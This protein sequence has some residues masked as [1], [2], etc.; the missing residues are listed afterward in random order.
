MIETN[1]ERSLLA[2]FDEQIQ[3]RM[4]EANAKRWVDDILALLTD[5]DPFGVED[6]ATHRIP[7][8]E[9]DPT[10][11]SAFRSARMLW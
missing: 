3:L 7:I 10:S 1:R 6:L 2:M 5:E 4:G 9:G 11:T 8:D